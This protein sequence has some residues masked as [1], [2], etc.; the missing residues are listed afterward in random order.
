MSTLPP[1]I[2]DSNVTKTPTWLQ[3]ALG[4]TGKYVGW[5]AVADVQELFENVLN[6]PS[7]ANDANQ[8]AQC[9]VE[10]SLELCALI[11]NFYV[12]PYAGTDSYILGRLSEWNAKLA[13]ANLM[14]RVVG[15]NGGEQQSAWGL[16]QRAFVE[17]NILSLMQGEERWDATGGHDATVRPETPAYTKVPL[18]LVT[19]SPFSDDPYQAIPVFSMSRTNYR[20]PAI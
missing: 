15:A 8:V 17:A 4:G 11:G 2:T 19:P 9:I 3:T 13:A 6:M 16:A 1:T 18:A 12:M 5:C 7:S 14:L 10:A 20:K